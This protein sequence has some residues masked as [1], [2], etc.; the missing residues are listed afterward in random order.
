MKSLAIKIGLSIITILAPLQASIL[1][2]GFLIVADLIMGLIA[3]HKTG[4]K[5]T[6]RRLKDTAVKMLVYNLL[7][8][9]GFVAQTYLIEFIPFT[10]IVLS[11]LAI[12]EIY[13]LGESFQKITGLS[14]VK[15]LKDQINK[16]L[17]SNPK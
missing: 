5:I 9:S 7:L 17:N 4:E 14:F 13:S 3:A 1:A 6:S 15:Y 10:K 8:V 12:V 2:I 11:F 16:H